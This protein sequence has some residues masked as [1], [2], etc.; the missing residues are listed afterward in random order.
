MPLPSPGQAWGAH[1]KTQRERKRTTGP[2]SQNGAAPQLLSCKGVGQAARNMF[3]QGYCPA[4]TTVLCP[5]SPSN[6]RSS[7]HA[8]ADAK[9]AACI[10][11]SAHCLLW[12]G[13]TCNAPF[14][15]RLCLSL[16]DDLH[17]SHI[18]G[19]SLNGEFLRCVG[20]HDVRR[21]ELAHTTSATRNGPSTVRLH[22]RTHAR[23]QHVS[24][25]VSQSISLLFSTELW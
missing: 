23:H 5:G 2:R 4:A 10:I 3:M 9:L 1:I 21:D 17:V 15:R 14:R 12:Y 20:L 8:H 25:S 22:A 16:I 11:C 7:S 18:R 19:W 6:D 13:V 24:L